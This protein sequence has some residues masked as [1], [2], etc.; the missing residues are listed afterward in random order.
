M[1]KVALVVEDDESLG[2]LYK[3][4]LELHGFKVTVACDGEAGLK[5]ASEMSPTIV[6]LDIMLPKMNGLVVL[7][8]LK[9]N[10][11]TK[12]IPVIVL[13]NF[14]QEQTVKEAFTKGA[15]DFILKYRVTPAEVVEKVE[16]ILN[17]KHFDIPE[18]A[19]LEK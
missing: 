3:I 7:E 16:N 9:S 12:A 18:S 1:E 13:T 6:L 10:E 2:K 14:G 15:E 8:N 17:P 5:L 19:T 11:K 4:E